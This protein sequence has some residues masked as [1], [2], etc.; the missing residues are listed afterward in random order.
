MLN[1]EK[2]LEEISELAVEND[3]NYFGCTQSVLTALQEKLNIGSRDIF[4]A[5]SALAGGVA[6]CGETCGALT[7]GYGAAKVGVEKTKDMVSE[8][9]RSKWLGERSVGHPDPGAMA[10]LLMLGSLITHLKKENDS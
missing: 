3:M 8:S 4:K 7:E 1:R 2:L 6:R 10:F 5:G 9:G